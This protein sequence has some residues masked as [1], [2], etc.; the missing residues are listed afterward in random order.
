M[1]RVAPHSSS[2]ARLQLDAILPA[3]SDLGYGDQAVRGVEPPVILLHVAIDQ[4]PESI[5]RA[6]RHDLGREIIYDELASSSV[7]ALLDP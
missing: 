7:H 2:A 5:D 6:A 3:L 1:D 4:H